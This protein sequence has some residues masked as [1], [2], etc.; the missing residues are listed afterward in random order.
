M[1]LV[2][3]CCVS[4]VRLYAPTQV[5]RIYAHSNTTIDFSNRT[6]TI[7]FCRHPTTIHFS[8][9][10]QHCPYPFSSQ[11]STDTITHNLRFVS[12]YK[13]TIAEKLGLPEPPKKPI[14]NY[15][16]F[17]EHHR[18]DVL[19][20]FPD[21]R[22]KVITKLSH[23][24]QNLS[25]A[26]KEEWTQKSE[27][28]KAAYDI[29]YINYVKMMNPKDLNKMKKLEKKLKNK[30]QQKY[31][32]RRKN[33]EGEKL[34]KPKLPNSPFMMFLELLKIPELSRKNGQR[35]KIRS[36][37]I[38]AEDNVQTFSS[39]TPRPTNLRERISNQ[40]T[41]LELCRLKELRRSGW[42]GDHLAVTLPLIGEYC[43][44]DHRSLLKKEIEHMKNMY[45]LSSLNDGVLF[46]RPCW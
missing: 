4:A 25:P 34:G 29:Q 5:P 24:W 13:K 41:I 2:R 7:H 44:H 23:L 35:R 37:S 27:R 12:S 28:E 22:Q 10:E 15:F 38:Q 16:H 33:I 14:S 21:L 9:V 42:T 8:P 39:S 19:K 20:E 17:L 40:E 45:S 43:S 26:E 6:S 36:S 30:K 32:R 1:A 11:S 46:L 3:V 18:E 31:I